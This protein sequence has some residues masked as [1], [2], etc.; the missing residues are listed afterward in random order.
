MRPM[1]QLSHFDE[2]G[3]SRMVDVGGKAETERVARASAVV[4]MR[5]ETL[6]LIRDRK[7]SK[8]DVM[9]IEADDIL[10]SRVFDDSED[11]RPSGNAPKGGSN[12]S[13]ES[14][15]EGSNKS[16]ESNKEGSNGGR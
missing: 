9:R 15:E 12:K 7:L 1:S 10:Q 16:E 8:G 13:K 5:P 11:E 2:S 14:N 6:A 4:R 3:A